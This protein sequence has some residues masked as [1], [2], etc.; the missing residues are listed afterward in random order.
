MVQLLKLIKYK[1]EEI[2]SRLIRIDNALTNIIISSWLPIFYILILIAWFGEHTI[3]VEISY[4]KQC[5]ELNKMC[6]STFLK[7]YINL[8]LQ[9]CLVK[10]RSTQTLM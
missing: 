6:R 2:T 4:I 3:I 8:S 5:Q 7:Q 10:V 9:K 1:L